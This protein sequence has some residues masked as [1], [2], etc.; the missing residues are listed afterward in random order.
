MT[1]GTCGKTY[2]DYECY[3]SLKVKLPGTHSLKSA[4]ACGSVTIRSDIG[5]L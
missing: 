2:G 3:H 1:G 5:S 4:N